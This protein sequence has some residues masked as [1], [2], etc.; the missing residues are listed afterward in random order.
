[1]AKVP[2]LREYVQSHVIPDAQQADPQFDGV[3]EMWFDSAEAFQEALSTP[4]GQA[5]L[6]DLANFCDPAK[7]QM[8]AVEDVTFR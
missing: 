8:F 7:V 4:E 5:A 3:V 2:G 1:V 6:T